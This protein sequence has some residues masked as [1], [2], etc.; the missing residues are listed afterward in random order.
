MYGTGN[1]P[2]NVMIERNVNFGAPVLMAIILILVIMT[3]LAWNAAIIA[4]IN[5][6]ALQKAGFTANELWSLFGYAIIISL[7][8]LILLFIAYSVAMN[9]VREAWAC[10]AY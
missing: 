1:T 6:F 2:V 8:L 10:G 4:A 5:Q 9:K 7:I 3:A